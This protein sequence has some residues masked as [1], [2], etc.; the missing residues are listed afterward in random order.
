M[1][2]PGFPAANEFVLLDHRPGSVFRWLQSLQDPD[3]AFVVLDPR[4]VDDTYP[5]HLVRKAM[6]F[7]DLPE[8]EEVVVLSLCTIPPRPAKP[9]VNLLAPIGVGLKTRKG[10]QVVLHETRYGARMEFMA[11]RAA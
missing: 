2:I 6:G 8:D 9:T 11:A 4:L 1:G 7:L 3:L 10:A 5:I